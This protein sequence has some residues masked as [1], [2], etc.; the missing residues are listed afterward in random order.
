MTWV[1]APDGSRDL[2]RLFQL[3]PEHGASFRLLYDAIWR[4]TK[5]DP[6]LLELCRLRIAQLL[7]CE[8][9][10]AVRQVAA[11]QAGLSEE[12]IAS[13]SRYPDSPLYSERERAC[14]AYAEQ[15][16]A[17][18]LGL[19]DEEV[20]AVKAHLTDGEFVGLTIAVIYFEAFARFCLVL[21]VAPV[22]E[23]RAGLQP[24]AGRH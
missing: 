5:V 18:H 22:A 9:E 7:R 13:L 16:V 21:G 17:D 19:T 12:K 15:L 20:A 11:R 14:L 4:E 1:P 23:V 24:V 10:L 8:A 2:D 3:R 6:V